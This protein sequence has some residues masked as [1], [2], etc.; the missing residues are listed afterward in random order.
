MQVTT[1]PQRFV[2]QSDGCAVEEI[3]PEGSRFK[4]IAIKKLDD[5]IEVRALEHGTENVI[6]FTADLTETLNQGVEPT[7]DTR[8]AD[9]DDDIEDALTLVSYTLID[10]DVQGY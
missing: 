5:S 9:I 4:K 2:D 10:P 3:Q 7:G 1:P 6:E 8:R